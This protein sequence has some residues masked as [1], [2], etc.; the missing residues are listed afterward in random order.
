MVNIFYSN[1]TSALN[2]D[3]ALDL[4]VLASKYLVE[5]LVSVCEKIILKDITVDNCLDI[6]LVADSIASKQFKNRS[7]S[8]ISANIKSIM[9]TPRWETLKVQ[10]PDLLIEVAANMMESLGKLI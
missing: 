3:V 4:I 2:F 7:F 8:Y 10:K 1:D 5:D 9:M 6:L